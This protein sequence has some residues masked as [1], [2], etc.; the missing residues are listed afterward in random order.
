VLASLNHPNIAMI[1]G[2]EGH[3]AIR[4]IVLELVEGETLAERLARGPI[5]IGEGAAGS[6]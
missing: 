6:R 5:R 1:H 2:V 4:A 3:D